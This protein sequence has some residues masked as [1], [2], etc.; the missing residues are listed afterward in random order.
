G[1]RGSGRGRS[2]GRRVGPTCRGGGR[3]PSRG[4]R[5]RGRARRVLPRSARE[6][7][8]ARAGALLPVAA[9]EPNGEDPA[10]RHPRRA[11]RGPVTP[12]DALT[13]VRLGGGPLEPRMATALAEACARADAEGA[14]RVVIVTAADDFPGAVAARDEAE[15]A[16]I[17]DAVAALA[18]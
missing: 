4:A 5:R 3:A 12:A 15:H 8:E 1:R 10:P 13:I 14:V 7:Q 16:A 17:A 18:A 2:S 6:L 9:Q 11:R